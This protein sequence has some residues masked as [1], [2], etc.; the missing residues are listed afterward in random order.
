MVQISEDVGFWQSIE[1]I[2]ELTPDGRRFIQQAF[3]A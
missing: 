1:G 3:S 2:P